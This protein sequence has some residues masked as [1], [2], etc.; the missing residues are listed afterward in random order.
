LPQN[1]KSLD[2]KDLKQGET[3]AYKPAYKKIQ[4]TTSDSAESLPQDL[5]E[6]AV[7]WPHLPDHIKAA[8]KALIQTSIQGDR[9]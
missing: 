2:S 9:L 7:A 6:V 8:I 3:G 5:A 1:D 4:K